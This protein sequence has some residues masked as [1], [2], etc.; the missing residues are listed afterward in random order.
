MD[1][2]TAHHRGEK[3]FA[4]QYCPYRGT[5]S[6]LLWHHKRQRHKVEH[7]E[8]KK[9]KDKVRMKAYDVLRIETSKRGLQIMKNKKLS[10]KIKS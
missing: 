5:S 10:L 8:E 9:D 1:H 3:P 6:S 2:K 4:C 7:E